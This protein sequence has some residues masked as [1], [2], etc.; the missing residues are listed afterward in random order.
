M[1]AI[2]IAQTG[3]IGL[4]VARRKREGASNASVNRET[5]VL[6]QMFRLAADDEHRVLTRGLVPQIRK[7]EEPPPRQG[8]V[9]EGQFGE[10]LSKLPAWAVAPIKAIN[11]TGWRVRAVLSRRKIDVSISKVASS[12]LIASRRRIGPLTSGRWLESSAISSAA[13][14]IRSCAMSSG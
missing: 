11:I 8:I 13:G 5:Q 6:G 3:A 9:T 4:Y 10:I 7:L 2:E 12:S 14:S 1:K